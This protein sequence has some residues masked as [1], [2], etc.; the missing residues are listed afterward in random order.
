MT[1]KTFEPKGNQSA[2]ITAQHFRA[3]RLRKRT[4]AQYNSMNYSH[5]WHSG[6]MKHSQKTIQ[7]SLKGDK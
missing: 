6:Q 3:K 1:A 5:Y 7:K 2:L 4:S